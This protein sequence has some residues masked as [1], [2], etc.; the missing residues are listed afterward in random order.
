MKTG[1]G[2]RAL[3]LM[4]HNDSLFARG[5]IEPAHSG[6]TPFVRDGISEMNRVGI[7][8]MSFL[9]D[10]GPCP[11]DRPFPSTRLRQALAEAGVQSSDLDKI[12]GANWSRVLND[13]LG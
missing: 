9:A 7:F 6:R 12:M 4:H 1:K 2:L 8:M 10:T 13:V 5:A 3:P 11:K